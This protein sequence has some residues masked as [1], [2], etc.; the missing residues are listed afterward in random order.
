METMHLLTLIAGDPLALHLCLSS[1]WEPAWQPAM[2]LRLSQARFPMVDVLAKHLIDRRNDT[3][4]LESHQVHSSILA[5]LAHAMRWADTSVV[6]AD[7]TTLLPALIQVLSWDVQI[8]WNSEPA[9][10]SPG[11]LAAER[12]VYSTHAVR[13]SVYAKAHSACMASFF[14][15]A[16]RLVTWRKS[17]WRP[18]SKAYCMACAM[19][20]W[21]PSAALPLRVNPTGSC[22]LGC[23]SQRPWSVATACARSWRVLQVRLSTDS[24]AGK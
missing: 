20:L 4:P 11:L 6:L 7:S 19:H 12:Y 5:F 8:L 1:Q 16:S 2:N 24:S 15:K 17:C 23:R 14:L 13:W 21:W 9:V 18:R 3:P 22:S 10:P